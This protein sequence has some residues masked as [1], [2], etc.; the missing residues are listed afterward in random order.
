MVV[1]VLEQVNYTITLNIPAI[2]F[3]REQPLYDHLGF[4]SFSPVSVFL[5]LARS[6]AR[7][8]KIWS[9]KHNPHFNVTID[10]WTFKI[11]TTQSDPFFAP[12]YPTKSL[13]L[14]LWPSSQLRAVA[15]IPTVVPSQ[16]ALAG[17]DGECRFED[18]KPFIKS[19][20]TVYLRVGAPNAPIGNDIRLVR[21]N[22]SQQ[23]NT[24]CSQSTKGNPTLR[25]TIAKVVA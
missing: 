11:Q 6:S 25:H 10:A 12:H 9:R 3:A 15:T 20:N 8:S 13:L 5:Y 22:L 4:W 2:T 7:T 21:Q 18:I 14:L 19:S 17:Q 24:M 1:L 23:V 16:K